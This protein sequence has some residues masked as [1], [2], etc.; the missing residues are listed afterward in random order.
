MEVIRL[1][2]DISAALEMLHRAHIVHVDTHAD[3]V[4]L[5]SDPACFVLIDYSGCTGDSVYPL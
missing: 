2:Y 5:R 3:N 1:K 4:M